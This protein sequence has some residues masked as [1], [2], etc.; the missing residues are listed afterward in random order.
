M[1]YSAIKA[2]SDRQMGIPVHIIVSSHTIF[3]PHL[4]CYPYWVQSLQYPKQQD[5]QPGTALAELSCDSL[6]VIVSKSEKIITLPGIHIPCCCFGFCCCC[7]LII[8]LHCFSS[9]NWRIYTCTEFLPVISKIIWSFYLS[10]WVVELSVHSRYI[11]VSL[12]CNGLNCAKCCLSKCSLW[13][14]FMGEY[15]LSISN[16]S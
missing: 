1:A 6:E 4:N 2:T 11:Q 8:I 15:I 9:L 14:A 5:N 16:P 7:C 12:L 10:V 3:M 13:N